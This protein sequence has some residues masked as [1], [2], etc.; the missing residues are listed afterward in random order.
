[1][2]T[3]TPTPS[4]GRQ[5]IE[6]LLADPLAR[7]PADLADEFHAY[8]NLHYRRYLLLVNLLGQAAYLSYALADLMLI[9][10]VGDL[11]LMARGAYFLVVFPVV[12]A[13]FRWSKNI[14]LLDLLLPLSILGAAVIWFALLAHSR[15]PHVVTFQ[16]ASIIFI[17]LANL[18]VQ[19]RFLPS[20]L[21]SVL[22][23]GVIGVGVHQLTRDS[24]GESLVFTLVYLPVFLFSIFISWS[25][26]L[27]RRRNFLRSLQGALLQDELHAAN[28]RLAEQAYTDAL[29]GLN[30]RGHFMTLA[31][32]EFAR[33]KR[34]QENL[35]LLYFDVDH[36]KRINDSHGHAAGDLVL[37]AISTTALSQMREQDIL[38]RMG[39][40][41]F[42]ALLPHT[43]LD[44][45]LMVAERL[46]AS[47]AACVVLSDTGE[48]LRFT[49]SVGVAKL[50]L[51]G[52]D[53]QALLR[54][55]DQALYQAKAGGR[56]RVCLAMAPGIASPIS[57]SISSA[58]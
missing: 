2:A 36:F 49:I 51:H 7:L 52:G 22:I 31:E 53:L 14:A 45:A 54:S 15:S 23:S 30:N 17:V 8:Q 38:A 58:A 50:A 34:L 32:R 5:R 33:V 25:T 57:T 56:N 6:Q 3:V 35:S 44:E 11:S 43:D 26:T 24:S 21:V 29:T 47:M 46:R 12:L 4:T 27:D 19:V 9:P 13:L 48:P 39:G 41:E 10:D 28:A 18:G 40:E 55:A 42:V 1:M 16:Y 37:R 20:L